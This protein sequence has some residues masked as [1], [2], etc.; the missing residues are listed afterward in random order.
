M[1]NIWQTLPKPIMALAPMENVT[2]TVFR[3]IVA[4]AGRPSVFFTEFTNCDGLFSQGKTE[5]EHRLKYTETE[6]PLIAQIWG[7]HPKTYYEAAKLVADMGFDGVDIN[8]GCPDRTVVKKGACSAL[9]NNHPLAHEIIE[10]TREGAAGRI[11]VSVKTRI[12]FGSIVTEEWIGFLLRLKPDA[13][14]VHLRTVREMSKV[15]AHWEEMEKTAKLRNEIS[16]ETVLLG[17]GD[18]RSLDEAKKLTEKYDIDGIM[19]G[20]G[21]FENLWLFNPDIDPA[22]ITIEGRLQILLKHIDLFEATWHDPRKF[23]TIKK[24]VKA[25]V[26]S[27]PGASD[28][29]QE[30]ME[31]KTISELRQAVIGKLTGPRPAIA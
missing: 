6:R 28:W 26:H 18:V 31:T 11:P 30:M 1:Q 24:F 7:I 27:F 17:N 3:R 13:L 20:R 15:P 12:G 9:I 14:T 2:D 19:L 21:I 16:P 8:M 4:E 23:Q 29:R 5:T 10:A 25:Y 22:Q